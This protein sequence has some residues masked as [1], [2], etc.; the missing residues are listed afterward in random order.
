MTG[1]P[2]PSA[3]HYTHPFVFLLLVIPF[4]ATSGFLGV[5]VVYLLGRAGVDPVTIAVLTGLSFLPHTFKFLYAPLV[6]LTLSRKQWYVMASIASALG[7]ALLG[8]IP[9]TEAGLPWLRVLVVA[10][11]FAT[12][13]L[14]MAV[15]SLMA[16]N[17]APGQLGRTAGWFQAGNLGGGGLGGGLALV[18]AENT[19]VA[20]LPG[21]VLAAVCLLTGFAILY[22]TEPEPHL[23]AL[24]DEPQGATSW[25][26]SVPVWRAVKRVFLDLWQVASSRLGYLGLLICFLPIGSGAAGSL[27]P[28]FAT[29]WGASAG[30]VAA[31]SG[32]LSGLLS[33]VGCMVGG[34]FCDRMDRKLAYAV[35]G[36]VMSVCAVLMAWAPHNLTMYYVFVLSYGF[37]S[38]LCY[39]AFTAV[40]LEAIG[41]GAVATKYSIFA[42][43]SNT[44]IAYMGILNSHFYDQSG[45]NAGLYSDAAMG[46]AGVLFFLLVTVAS[47]ALLKR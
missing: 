11:N 31:T 29:E 12:A 28:L 9:A 46:V 6:D 43:L 10:G 1:T 8:M 13:F 14:S 42:S 23:P 25:P 24:A 16:Y 21:V 18:I 35:F 2:A 36:L 30:D 45:S 22:T 44:P 38:G 47:R 17:T 5:T 7:I 3:R 27:F 39:A 32:A 33:A 26:H 15:E 40:T 20:W 19:T 41:T 4:G 37:I 34:Y